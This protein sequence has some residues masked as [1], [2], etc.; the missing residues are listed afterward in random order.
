MCA[1]CDIIRHKADAKVVY[2]TD[3]IIA[4]LDIDPISDGH[5][6]VLPK[7][8]VDSITKLSNDYL[9]EIMDIAKKIVQVFENKYEHRGYTIMQNGGECC[10]FGHF[11]LHV[12]PRIKDDGFGWKYPEYGG[13]YTDEIA[14]DLKEKLT[15]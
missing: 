4:F 3:K 5:V 13:R 6:L 14:L 10:D 2:E 15:D 11:H 1:F 7:I 9:H 12:F 8:H